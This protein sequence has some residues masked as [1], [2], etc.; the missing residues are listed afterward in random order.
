MPEPRARA[1]PSLT[2]LDLTP[3]GFP[4]G[5]H[6]LG[7]VHDKESVMSDLAAIVKAYDVRGTVPDQVNEDVTRALGAA[8]VQTLR[9]GGDAAERIV[10]AHDMRE[11]SPGLARAFA[12]GARA[13][14]ADVVF[15]GLG[16]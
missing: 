4:V 16:S 2:G 6:S 13:E 1:R 9:A 14:G 7:V 5:S 15:A 10:V 12:E 3:S 8:F 11:T